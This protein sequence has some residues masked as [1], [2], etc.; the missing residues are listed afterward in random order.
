MN[1]HKFMDQCSIWV[2]LIND[3]NVKNIERNDRMGEF[4]NRPLFILKSKNYV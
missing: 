3:L 4:L 2:T 1:A